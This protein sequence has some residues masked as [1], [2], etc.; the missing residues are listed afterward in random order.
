MYNQSWYS[1]ELN[2]VGS[3]GR[4]EEGVI[5]SDYHESLR[6]RP[7]NT[8]SNPSGGKIILGIEFQHNYY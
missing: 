7:K 5:R 1:P 8:T 2:F 6:Q 3:G 4:K